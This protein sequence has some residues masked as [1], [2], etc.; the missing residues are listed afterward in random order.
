MKINPLLLQSILKN[1]KE[2]KKEAG[3]D[4]A[5]FLNNSA[6]KFKTVDQY[7]VNDHTNVLDVAN[8]IIDNATMDTVNTPMTAKELLEK[9]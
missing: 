2:E 4:A 8:S 9:L 6:D 1:K 5:S 7:F 3:L